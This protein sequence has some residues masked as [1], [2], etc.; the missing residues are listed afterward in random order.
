MADTN[1]LYRPY[2]G[3]PIRKGSKETELVKLIQTA[4]R[5][6]YVRDDWRKDNEP[7][8]PESVLKLPYKEGDKYYGV[9]GPATEAAVKQVQK[10]YNLG[11]DG[12]VGET[13]WGVL[14]PPA[15]LE[16]NSLPSK[17]I[18]IPTPVPN[19]SEIKISLASAETTNKKIKE[20]QKLTN[21]DISKIEESIP[22]D[23]KPKGKDKLGVLVYQL[24]Q[25]LKEYAVPVAFNLIQEFGVDIIEQALEEKGVSAADLTDPK[26]LAVKL[27]QDNVDLEDIKQQYCPLPS[28]LNDIIDQR[29]NITTFLNNSGEQLNV[30]SAT[31]TFSSDFAGLIQDIINVTS[32]VKTTATIAM[33]AIPLAL[34]GAVPAAI[35]LLGDMAS[36]LTFTPNGT[37]RIPPYASV[38]GQISAPVSM[39]Q[40]T[41]VSVVELLGKLDILIN[42]C[43]PS[44]TLTPVSDNIKKIT[45]TQA[46]GNNTDNGATYK[47][48][49]IEIEKVPYTD[50]VTRYKAVGKNQYGITMIQTPLSF[51]TNTQTLINELK[52]II[53]KGNL[54]AY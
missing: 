18:S 29:N 46:I 31:A 45:T 26:G 8:I 13:T 6:I 7:F 21:P 33:S 39:T 41:I 27:A 30:M 40:T 28:T 43:N 17:G 5:D 54:E 49:I 50:T 34:P 4:L 20:K 53:D 25:K 16:I 38:A 35:D 51:T 14:F 3:T 23:Q 36:T 24:G 9:F 12:V 19:L 37:P 10:D 44:A 1:T 48:F 42:L 22:D 47:G 2:P 15:L 11:N 32:T 52:L